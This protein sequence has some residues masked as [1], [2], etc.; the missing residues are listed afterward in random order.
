MLPQRVPST[1]SCKKSKR[2]AADVQP[3]PKASAKKKKPAPKRKAAVSVERRVE[4]S[5]ACSSSDHIEQESAEQNEFD[6]YMA[7]FSNLTLVEEMDDNHDVATFVPSSDTQ[8]FIP[9]KSKL[10]YLRWY[11]RYM[12][13]FHPKTRQQQYLL[14]PAVSAR[15]L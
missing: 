1:R 12:N 14:C 2:E 4:V 5:A 13:F 15:R 3:P 11:D 7:D 9:D 6:S 8:K 10:I